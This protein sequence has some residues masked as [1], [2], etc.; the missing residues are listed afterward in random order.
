MRSKHTEKKENLKNIEKLKK[1]IASKVGEQLEDV[2][3][4]KIMLGKG[5]KN[6]GRTPRSKG[7]LD[8]VK[9]KQKRKNQFKSKGGK[10]KGG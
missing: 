2:E 8:T 6:S 5:Q 4:D 1:K 3:F 7:V 9:D 10:K